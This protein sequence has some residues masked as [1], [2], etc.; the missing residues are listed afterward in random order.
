VGSA[1]AAGALA[2]SARPKA[3]AQ[4]IES[5]FMKILLWWSSVWRLHH[6]PLFRHIVNMYM[7]KVQH[8]IP[9]RFANPNFN[10]SCPA[11]RSQRRTRRVKNAYGF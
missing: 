9:W 7:C 11:Q 2:T 1:K 5:C 3:S 8:E 6:H 4:A 10:P